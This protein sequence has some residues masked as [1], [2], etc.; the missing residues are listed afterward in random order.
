MCVL[1]CCTCVYLFLICSLSEVC[2]RT[3]PAQWPELLSLHPHPPRPPPAPAGSPLVRTP[4]SLCSDSCRDHGYKSRL[5]IWEEQTLKCLLS[6]CFTVP[7]PSSPEAAAM[8]EEVTRLRFPDRAFPR[9]VSVVLRFSA[10]DTQGLYAQSTLYTLLSSITAYS[11]ST[12][13]SSFSFFI[14]LLHV[15]WLQVTKKCCRVWKQLLIS[16]GKFFFFFDQK[17]KCNLLW[18]WIN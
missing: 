15:W 6:L 2:S 8:L 12:S 5:W 17:Q 4:Y 10:E 13:F 1:V 9:A 16:A 3:L 18:E 11:R 7:Q 14:S